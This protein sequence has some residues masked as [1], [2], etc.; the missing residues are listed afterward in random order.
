MKNYHLYL[1]T[2]KTDNKKYVGITKLGYPNRFD[3]HINKAVSGAIA[4]L[5]DQNFQ[6][7]GLK[8]TASVANFVLVDFKNSDQALACDSFLRDHGITIGTSDEM[9]TCLNAIRLFLEQCL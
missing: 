5:E 7:M 8:T 4:S 2:N 1:I 3:I 9:E 6:D